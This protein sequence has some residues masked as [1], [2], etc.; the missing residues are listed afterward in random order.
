MSVKVP[1]PRQ[2]QANETLDTLTHWKSHVRNYFRRDDNLKPFFA[3]NSTWD[4]TLDD[5]GFVGNDAAARADNLE[6]LLDTISG[7]LPGP[8]LT[9]QITK[10]TSSI[11]EVFQ[12]IWNHYD[13][14]PNPSSFLDFDELALAHEER[15]ID[16]YYRMLYH[17]EQH[18]VKQGDNVAG[19]QV[20]RADTLSHSHKNLIA[21]NWLQKLSPNLVK[22][23]K[24]EKHKELKEGQQLYTMVN[25]ISKNV[26]EWHRRH[27]FNPPKTKPASTPD[28]VRHVK[29]DRFARGTGRGGSQRYSQ[30][31]PPQGPRFTKPNQSSNQSSRGFCPSCNYLSKEL[32]LDI[33][34]RHLPAQCPR[35]QTALRLL[36]CEEEYL[37]EHP[38]EEDSYED[39]EDNLNQPPQ[40]DEGIALKKIPGNMPNK[41]N[42]IWKAKS[43]TMSMLLNNT[44]VNAIIDEGSEISAI[45]SNIVEK[46]NTCISRT[47]EPAQAVGSLSIPVVGT[48]T[49]DVIIKKPLEESEIQ[50][51]LGQCLVINDLGCDILIGEPAKAKNNIT[52]HPMTKSIYTNDS[53]DNNVVLSYASDSHMYAAKMRRTT[54]LFPEEAVHLPVPPELASSAEVVIQPDIGKSFP[55]PGVYNV[56]NAQVRVENV[57]S[58]PVHI[59]QTDSFLCTQLMSNV[60]TTR[61]IYSLSKENMNQFQFPERSLN[62]HKETLADIV[63]D[64]DNLLSKEWKNIFYDLTKS[65]QD[66]ITDVPGRYNGAYGQVNCSIIFTE[67]PPPSVKPR[68]PN[69]PDGKLKILASLMDS[70]EEWGVLAKPE[71]LGIIP[72]HV[73]PCILVPKSE[74]KFR[75]VTDFRSIQNH[76]QLLPTIMPTVQDAMTALSA[77]QYHVELDF[78][79]YYWQNAIPIEDSEKLAICHPFGG[80]RVY[81]TSP[82]G[83]R[84]SAEW[85]SEIL[86]RIF[87]DM[88]REKKCTRIADQ[89]YVLGQSLEELAA[90]YE[91]ILSRA[92][93]SNLTFK[94][95]KVVICPNNTVIL[96]WKKTGNLWCPT[97]HVLSPLSLAEPPTTI[98]KLRGWLGAFRQIAKT[99]PNHAVVL[100]GLEKAVAGKNSRDKVPWSP[101]LLADFDKAKESIKTSKPVTIPKSTDKLKIFTDWSQDSDAV[102]G[103]L[104]IERLVEDKPVNL[105]GGE[106]SCRLKGAQTRWTP[107]EKECL[108]IK[109]LVQHYQPF[110]R[111]SANT[112]TIYTDNIVAVHAYAAVQQ[113]KISTSSR[114]ASFISTLC[115]NRLEIVHIPGELTKVADFNSRNPVHCTQPKCQTCNF[116]AYELDSQDNIIRHISTDKIPLSERPTWIDLQKQDPTI[117]QLHRLIK[118]GQTPEKKI[119]NKNLKL[120]HNMYRRGSLYIAPDN[121]IQVKHVD[122]V[123][124]L[125]Y[126]AILVP[127]II[128]PGL[129]QSLHLKLN[130]PSPHQLVKQISR[131]FYCIGM[132]KY[133]NNVSATCDV[134]IRLKTLPKEASAHTTT[135]N[136]V[137][138]KNF[139]ADILIEKGQNI[140]LIREKLS[141]FTCTKI[142]ENE[143]TESIQEALIVLLVDL[144]PD[145]GAVV[146]VDP[147]PALASLASEAGRTILDHFNIRLDV[148]R[149]NN[150]QKNPIAENAIK[151]FRREWLRIKPDGSVLS[152]TD[153]A[154]ITM[155]MNKRIRVNGISPKEFVLKRENLNHNPIHVQDNIEGKAQFDR[156]QKQNAQQ[157]IKDS[158]NKNPPQ[159]YKPKVGDRVFIKNDLSK[160][161]AREEYIVTKVFFKNNESWA[162]ARKSQ[163]GF[164]NKEYLLKLSEIFPAPFQSYRE[165]IFDLEEEEDFQG[166]SENIQLTKRDKLQSL[167]KNLE[168]SC[169]ETP[170][171]G[172]PRR[173][174]YSTLNPLNEDVQVDEDDE[175][176]VGFPEEDVKS[177]KTKQQRLQKLIQDLESDLSSEDPPF[178]GFS[179]QEVNLSTEKAKHLCKSLPEIAQIR[180]MNHKKNRKI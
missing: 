56:H 80:L 35:K 28:T 2:L 153:R 173:P 115:E 163:K 79:N 122:V 43:P 151:E 76:I 129:V 11:E 119:K 136:Q 6:G 38:E 156:R 16:L 162:M 159:L 171:R 172:R 93:Q 128:F 98:K 155:T 97:E 143:T 142:I 7:F 17:A 62:N 75:L 39:A 25:D 10:H 96:G 102:G 88:V 134:C 133:I 121:L 106:F 51:N 71:D 34:Y 154:E 118:Q 19:A 157:F 70:M 44:P 64:P 145:S 140:L 100:R 3:R 78:S 108:A 61:K 48:T 82:Q 69:Y 13:V 174:A 60:N 138:G 40:Q 52:T 170:K 72:T 45:S 41:I 18:L 127:E 161:R 9:A 73:H 23:V 131:Q 32:K 95:S 86:A 57:S 126:E 164:R 66:I 176:L 37:H 26:E 15:F 158:I 87:G 84:N 58:L 91:M 24:L 180:S 116:V 124:A 29:S 77:S 21:L 113:G 139:S 54:T 137:F 14:T 117:S 46:S 179:T 165:N 166:F 148:G 123:H 1:Y 89:I 59:E 85:G 169:K 90:N 160:S 178:H 81:T 12:V 168:N 175:I 135:E 130:H 112:S 42:A 65:Y 141:Q 94:P 55:P 22:I 33:N 177:L 152:D 8:Y 146:Q 109:L 67:K 125:Q 47:V 110:I 27:G 92:R 120:L 4:Q 63:I 30:P 83:L 147:G 114:V 107:C 167:I 144:I 103:R 74:G 111:E 49:S 20:A 132:A 68:L 53:A 50:W 101:E 31:F 104:V 150:K 99:I 105:N 149:V 36:R 5:Y